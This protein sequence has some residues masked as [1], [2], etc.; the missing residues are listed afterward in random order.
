MSNLILNFYKQ[1]GILI[2]KI[3]DGF[4]WVTNVFLNSIFSINKIKI[5]YNKN[6]KFHMSRK[7]LNYIYK[8]SYFMLLL[9]TDSGLIVNNKNIKKGGMLKG[10][11]IN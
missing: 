4:F 10:F 9:S 6:K 1:L 11:F 7:T 5:Y 8:N 3:N 2:F